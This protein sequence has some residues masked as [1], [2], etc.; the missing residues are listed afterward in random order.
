[1]N[2]MEM[3]ERTRDIVK[4]L[5]R[6]RF[7]ALRRDEIL[8]TGAMLTAIARE[9]GFTEMAEEMQHDM[10]LELPESLIPYL[11]RRAA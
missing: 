8:T 9:M 6:N 1:M 10:E 3:S 5:I 2:T 7:D 4:Q 11:N